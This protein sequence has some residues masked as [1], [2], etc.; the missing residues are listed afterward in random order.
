MAFLLASSL[1]RLLTAAALQSIRWKATPPRP[2]G[3]QDPEV[4][5]A[6]AGSP[7]SMEI[8]AS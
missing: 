7:E 3:P 8:P 4:S 2:R 6:A 1:L 5:P